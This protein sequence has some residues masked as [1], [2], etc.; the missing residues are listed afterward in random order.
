MLRTQNTSYGAYYDVVVTPGNGMTPGNGI[1][2]QYRGYT[3]EGA[4]AFQLVDVTGDGDTAPVFV[5]A[6]RVGTVFSAY[7][8][9]D[10]VNWTLIPGSSI[11]LPAFFGPL[12]AGLAVASHDPTLLNTV[13]FNA[14]AVTGSLSTQPPTVLPIQAGWNLIS[15]PL[16]PSTTLYASDVLATLVAQTGGFAE[17][18]VYSG[19]QWSQYMYDDATDGAGLGGTDFQLQTG[20]GYALYSDK[21]GSISFTGTPVSF[22]PPTVAAGWNLVGFPGATGTSAEAFSI[23]STLLG[24]IQGSYAEL[25]GYSHGQW[26]PSA[27]DDLSGGIGQSGPDFTVQSGQGYALFSDKATPP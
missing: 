13:V 23:L 15:L 11:N 21:A 19:G 16:T 20:Q 4:T 25:D 22:Q 6:A 17:I 24:Q 7:T 27:F 18:S 26:S 9:S 8:S 1:A 12:L 14:V 5:K 2:V 10:G 3:G